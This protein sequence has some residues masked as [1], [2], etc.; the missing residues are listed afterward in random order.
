MRTSGLLPG[1]HT[2]CNLDIHRTDLTLLFKVEI[3]LPEL[4]GLSLFGRENRTRQ[5]GKLPRVRHIY[6]LWSCES[7]HR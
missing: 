4:L 7:D 6:D 2:H 1:S 5:R 3:P